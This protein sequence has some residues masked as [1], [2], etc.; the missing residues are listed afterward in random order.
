MMWACNAVLFAGALGGVKSA[1]WRKRYTTAVVMVVDFIL[2]A[3]IFYGL[4][5]GFG[6]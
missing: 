1:I 4:V 6:G 3:A 5:F 2:A